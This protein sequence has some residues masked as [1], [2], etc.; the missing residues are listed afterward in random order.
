M[1]NTVPNPPA[2]S[3][4]IS[5]IFHPDETVQMCMTRIDK[6]VSDQQEDAPT[7]YAKVAVWGNCYYLFFIA[8]LNQIARM[9]GTK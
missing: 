7:Q 9:R 5:D 3:G 2:K 4:D 8:A 1:V 6:Y